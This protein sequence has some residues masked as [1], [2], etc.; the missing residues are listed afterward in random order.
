MFEIKSG[1]AINLHQKYLVF[2]LPVQM[3]FIT[4]RGGCKRPPEE[5]TVLKWWRCRVS[6]REHWKLEL[7]RLD[8]LTLTLKRSFLLHPVRKQN[9]KPEATCWLNLC[10]LSARSRSEHTHTHTHQHT[11]TQTQLQVTKINSFTDWQSNFYFL[12]VAVSPQLHVSRCVC[13]WRWVKPLL[14]V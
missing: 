10:S 9:L 2:T 8:S 3:N 1:P 14:E 6:A 7:R 13:V 4:V 12:C 11:H 5:G